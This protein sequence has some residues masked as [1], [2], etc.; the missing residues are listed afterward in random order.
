[1]HAMLQYTCE[2]ALYI[3]QKLVR[4][5]YRVCD[6]YKPR[7]VATHP[8]LMYLAHSPSEV[9]HV[10]KVTKVLSVCIYPVLITAPTVGLLYL[11][12]SS[13]TAWL[14]FRLLPIVSAALQR[15]STSKNITTTNSK[16]FLD[17]ASRQEGRVSRDY[18]L[19]AAEKEHAPAA[20]MASIASST[21]SS[22]GNSFA[23]TVTTSESSIAELQSSTDVEYLLDASILS[24]AK[25]HTRT[26]SPT[27]CLFAKSL[28]R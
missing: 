23:T 27:N 13:A 4:M 25:K 10:Q 3:Y 12:A 2:Q 17:S 24:H 11:T 21:L 16:P 15:P 18:T 26:E 14:T 20:A 22:G 28:L 8:R 9:V 6:S 7:V 5:Q 1:M 19:D